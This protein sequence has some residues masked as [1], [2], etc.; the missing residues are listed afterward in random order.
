MAVYFSPVGNGNQWLNQLGL[1]LAG[2]KINT[3]AA[4]TTTP[5][6]TYTDSTGLT[7]N[8]NPIILDA[9][10]RYAQEIW[11]TVGQG[12][13]FV[14]TDASG[15]TQFTLDNIP[16]GQADA[17]QLTYTPPGSGAV[18]T[19]VAA[20]L[21]LLVPTTPAGAAIAPG[22]YGV[23]TIAAAATTDIG[24]ITNPIITVSGTATIT[25]FGDTCPYGVVKK[26][27]MQASG[28]IVNPSAN[29]IIN[30]GYLNNLSTPPGGTVSYISQVNDVLDVVCIGTSGGH[31]VYRVTIDAISGVAPGF[32]GITSGNFG[33]SAN[34][35]NTTLSVFASQITLSDWQSQLQ[36]NG[37]HASYGAPGNSRSIRL[38]NVGN[39]GANL[40]TC[41]VTNAPGL[42]GTDGSTITS[43]P[44][45][46]VYFY[47][48]S[49]G[50]GVQPTVGILASTSSTTPQGSYSVTYPYGCLIAT[51]RYSTD[52]GVGA[53]YP[54]NKVCDWVSFS[55]N[56]SPSI[57]SGQSASGGAAWST[58]VYDN[59]NIWSKICPNGTDPLLLAVTGSGTGRVRLA[60]DVN[61][62]TVPNFDFTGDGA[63][64][65][66]FTVY[67]PVG[68]A[69]LDILSTDAGL[70][71]RLLGFN[72][73]G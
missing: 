41:T 44:A 4:G 59:T 36:A 26:L 9:S 62:R 58:V 56:S 17:T 64:A 47:L 22:W 50:V 23:G 25:S 63:H 43:T 34:A 61:T 16:N 65:W 49:D 69:Q 8:A 31:N 53:L 72:C 51:N 40:L 33:L 73:P 6:A 32:P 7:P 45:T 54:T 28:V 70:N 19:T 1:V 3:Y 57:F 14:I 38:V 5:T 12:Y 27:I 37:T 66:T 2:G 18:Q 21:N 11:L 55:N 67:V 35:L 42:G 71:I 15:V 10:G 20:E 68:Q 13:K 48:V 30:I 24:S 39:S 29:L 60:G 46:Q 52:L